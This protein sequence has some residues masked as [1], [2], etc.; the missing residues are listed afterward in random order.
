MT[1]DRLED[2]RSKFPLEPIPLAYELMTRSNKI[3]YEKLSKR[4]PDFI[5]AYDRWRA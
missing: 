2:A 3:D 5:A 4:D 1:N